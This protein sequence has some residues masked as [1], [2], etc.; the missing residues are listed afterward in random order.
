M[1]VTRMAAWVDSRG[2]VVGQVSQGVARGEDGQP[3][4]VY[5]AEAVGLPASGCPRFTC[6]KKKV[7][8]ALKAA[9]IRA[10]VVM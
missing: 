8:D 5:F 10:S 9:K 4:A 1:R 7:E 2:R 3:E 6:A